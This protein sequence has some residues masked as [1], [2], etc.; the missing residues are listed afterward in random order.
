MKEIFT[1]NMRLSDML[2]MNYS[3]VQVISRVGVDL[4]IL[5]RHSTAWSNL[6]MR[7]RRE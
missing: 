3:L 4:R 7:T 6:A 2:D 1:P 5:S